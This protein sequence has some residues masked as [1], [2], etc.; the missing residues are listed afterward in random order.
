MFKQIMI[1]NCGLLSKLQEI[2][3]I[4]IKVIRNIY[5]DDHFDIKDER[6]LLGKTLY[7]LS[8]NT[9]MLDPVFARSLQLI[10]LGLYEKFELAN[11]HL[12]DWLQDSSAN[13]VYSEAVSG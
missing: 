1:S 10:G 13:V 2:D 12:T 7:Y 5:Y 4:P 9:K 3:Y 11:Q 8:K 6:F